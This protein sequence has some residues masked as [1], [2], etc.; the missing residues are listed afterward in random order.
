MQ[1][2]MKL[3]IMIVLTSLSVTDARALV[4][5]GPAAQ[6]EAVTDAAYNHSVFTEV[7]NAAN[8]CPL[9]VDMKKWDEKM[10][11][12]VMAIVKAFNVTEQGDAWYGKRSDEFQANPAKE[13]AEA[14]KTYGPAGMRLMKRK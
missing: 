9:M 6:A 5:I 3:A 8:F 11:A 4:R 13:C 12:G 10:P 14:E 7:M 2:K 1:R